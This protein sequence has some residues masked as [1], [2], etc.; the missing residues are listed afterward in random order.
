[1]EL[2]PLVLASVL[3]YI[4]PIKCQLGKYN[5]LIIKMKQVQAWQ[6]NCIWWIKVIEERRI[7]APLCLNWKPPDYMAMVGHQVPLAYYFHISSY[8]SLYP[9]SPWTHQ[10]PILINFANFYPKLHW[11][12]AEEAN[13]PFTEK[14]AKDSRISFHVHK[15]SGKHAKGSWHKGLH[16]HS[17]PILVLRVR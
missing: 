6:T 15:N 9:N 13:N 11:L 10:K 7:M 5:H 4:L 2:F 1:M 12:S 17:S 3:A 16:F 14:D 8:R